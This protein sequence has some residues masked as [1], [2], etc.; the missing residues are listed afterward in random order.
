M[1]AVRQ[2]DIQRL[3]QL[4]RYIQAVRVHTGCR[5]GRQVDLAGFAFI[6]FIIHVDFPVLRP[7]AASPVLQ[8]AAI[9]YTMTRPFL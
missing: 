1:Q 4:D 8:P 2:V 5:A 7:N 9:K 6:I 3:R